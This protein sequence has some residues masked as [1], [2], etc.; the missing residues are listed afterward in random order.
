M[1][2]LTTI[3]MFA[4]MSGL[5]WVPMSPADEIQTDWSAGPGIPGPVGSWA[6]GFSEA[7]GIS[8]L[9]V[10]GQLSLA[11]AGLATG[12]PHLLADGQ[13]GAFGIATGDLDG[14][15]DIDIA[16]AAESSGRLTAWLNDGAAAP[17]FTAHVVD[18]AYPA[19]S[20]VSI[21][22]LD[23]DGDLDLVV[24]T[25]A[26]AQRLTCYLNDG[27]S[28]PAWTPS[29]LETNWSESWEIATGDVDGDG[30]L[31]VVGTNLGQ[32]D[33][34][35]WRNDGAAPIGWSRRTVDAAFSGAHSARA[36]DIDGDGRTDILGTGTTANEVAWW[37]NEGG[38]PV[39]WTKRVIAG[40]FFG[41]RSVRLGDIDGDGDLDAAACGFNHR[42]TWWANQGG[43]PVVWTEQLVSAAVGQA[44]QIQL[45]DLSGDGRLDIAAVAYGGSMVVWFENG[46]GT[47]PISWTRR[48]LDT[49]L[50]QPLA[51]AT[52]D[53]DGDGALEVIGSSN[54]GNLFRWY[55]ATS[56]LPD[57]ELT[58]SVLDLGAAAPVTLD[59]AAAVPSAGDLWFE[60][61]TGAEPGIL[62]PWSA[63]IGASGAL[64]EP[65]GRYLQYRAHLATSDP[66]SSPRLTEVALRRG[67][68]PAPPPLTGLGLEVHPNPANPRAVFAF[69][70]PQAM[71]ASLSVFD[72]SGRRVR[73]LAQAG[74]SAG[75]HEV[76]WDGADERGRA[77]PS[78]SYLALLA[79][80]QGML[81]SRVTLLR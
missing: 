75:R 11:S 7:A 80:R 17:V 65:D 58:G 76:A 1:R 79:T 29:H 10:P 59:W 67:L 50:P 53:V 3:I 8:W 24:C 16:G 23:A 64:I 6:A 15:G 26:I 12:N 74:F 32:G 37:R 46:G 40:G 36:G 71:T 31:D 19:V 55:D 41:G 51:L 70:L 43:S 22:D 2:T 60:V 56:F 28:P 42:V 81:R 69:T 45:A 25:G 44:H 62:G 77:V 48:N 27:G 57:G 47:A 4:L 34:V 72:A 78:G 38:D 68:S 18:A 39:T 52:G 21:A 49:Q 73:D 5:A 61:R 35:W 33:V 20:G 13:P 9:A 14:D 66:A 63:P 54:S 30:R